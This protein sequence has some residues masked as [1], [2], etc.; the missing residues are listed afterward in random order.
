[1]GNATLQVIQTQPHIPTVMFAYT[2]I[3]VPCLLSYTCTPA[4][5]MTVYISKTNPFS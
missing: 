4:G 1:M 2:G 5:V 3:Y